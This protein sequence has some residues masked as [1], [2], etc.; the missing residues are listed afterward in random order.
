MTNDLNAAR[1]AKLS[2]SVFARRQKSAARYFAM[3]ANRRRGSLFRSVRV[4][5]RD[6]VKRRNGLV[7]EK[8]ECFVRKKRAEESFVIA[9]RQKL[10]CKDDK[11]LDKYL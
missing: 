6:L 4:V 11:S 10:H 2:G 8:S 1:R 7:R 9:L 3:R 5:S